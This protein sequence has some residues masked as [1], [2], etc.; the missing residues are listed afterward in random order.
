MV[1]VWCG[2]HWLHHNLLMATAWLDA[3][4]LRQSQIWCTNL[5][6]L[7]CGRRYTA[8]VRWFPLHHISLH[9]TALHRTAAY[10]TAPYRTTHHQTA[11]WHAATYTESYT[12][13]H[14]TTPA[15]HLTSGL[16]FAQVASLGA[17]GGAVNAA[18]HLG[19]DMLGQ[20]ME[21]LGQGIGQ[22]GAGQQG[23]PTGPTA[24]PTTPPSPRSIATARCTK[25]ARP[26]AA[27]FVA[28]SQ[29]PGSVQPPTAAQPPIASSPVTS[30]APSS[31]VP[32]EECCS[33]RCPSFCRSIALL[34]PLVRWVISVDL[35]T[36]PIPLPPLPHQLAPHL[37]GLMPARMAVA[38]GRALQSPI[39]LPLPPPLPISPITG[40]M[41]P[42]TSLRQL[43][44]AASA[45][46][47]VGRLPKGAGP[48]GT[49]G[50]SRTLPWPP[51]SMGARCNTALP[52]CTGCWVNLR[53]AV[54]RCVCYC[55]RELLSSC[56]AIGCATAAC[57]SMWLTVTA[58]A[59]AL[60]AGRDRFGL[61]RAGSA[62]WCRPRK[63]S[64]ARGVRNGSARNATPSP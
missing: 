3:L 11:P 12:T 61:R 46:P 26:A 5:D 22:Q 62:G 33:D 45:S 60:R 44:R 39:L 30:S 48:I 63:S 64:A 1:G 56:V 15:A 24:A 34:L 55:R 2:C 13:P 32:T 19:W 25:P 47:P 42:A 8:Q 28:A 57:G 59:L 6:S 9:R 18:A 52:L 7:T 49:I 43:P 50:V 58:A 10:R 37:Y 40:V 35:S 31:S 36:L 20:G 16:L 53:R 23:T 27:Q 21:Q 14:H 54:A 29:P 4:E 38:V 51:S 17:E 41:P